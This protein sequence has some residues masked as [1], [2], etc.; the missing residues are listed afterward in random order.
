MSDPRV[1]IC[2]DNAEFRMGLRALLE[3]NGVD[4]V[5]EVSDGSEVVRS[6]GGGCSPT[7]C[8]WT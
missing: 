2:D 3:V 7:S 8:S 4:V 5:G 6:R 1:L